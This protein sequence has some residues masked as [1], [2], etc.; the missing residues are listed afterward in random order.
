MF[1]GSESQK[2]PQ[3]P[4]TSACLR[5]YFCSARRFFSNRRPYLQAWL[6]VD[7]RQV[8]L[9]ME[10]SIMF[11]ELSHYW[12]NSAFF[13]IAVT[14]W[15]GDHI[16][17]LMAGRHT[18]TKTHSCNARRCNLASVLKLKLIF[19]PCKRTF[20]WNALMFQVCV[21]DNSPNW[22]KRSGKMCR[23]W[24]WPQ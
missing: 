8:P 1:F 23:Y 5:L 19:N 9:W 13:L 15:N 2:Q 7:C 20:D 18:H 21:H 22:W 12:V 6:R 16:V 17:S 24:A 10:P 3:Y 11:A 4:A 14:V